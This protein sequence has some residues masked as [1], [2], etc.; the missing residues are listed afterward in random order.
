MSKLRPLYLYCVFETEKDVIP[1]TII[2]S[3]IQTYETDALISKISED[4]E[5]SW[6]GEGNE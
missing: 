2:Y 3:E 4:L 6:R 5:K 1:F